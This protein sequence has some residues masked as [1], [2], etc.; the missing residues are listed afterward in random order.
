[1]L[2]DLLG[3][4]NVDVSRSLLVGD[5]P[6]DIEAAQGAG[7]VG[8]LF[9]GGDLRDFTAPLLSRSDG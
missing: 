6:S 8:H 4:W 2:L 7:I 9:R 1:M 3:R 5:K